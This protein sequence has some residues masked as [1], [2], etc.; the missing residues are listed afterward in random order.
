VLVEGVPVTSGVRTTFDLLRFASGIREAVMAGDGCLRHGFTTADELVA[1]ALARPGWRGVAQVR[2][3]VPLLD[4]RAESRKESELRLIWLDSGL[5]V[6]VP[7]VRIAD[8]LGLFIA[9]VDLFDEKAG[10]VG[11]YQGRLHREG[12]RPWSD[13]NRNRRLDRVGLEVVE[14]WSPDVSGSDAV[15]V[16]ALRGGY[17]RAARRDPAERTYLILTDPALNSENPWGDGLPPWLD[18]G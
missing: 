4:G 15:A 3:A 6:P 18:V 5:G 14:F 8:E 17:A 12:T 1:Y 2:A 7:Q 11:E 13:V 9:R 16:A 10:V